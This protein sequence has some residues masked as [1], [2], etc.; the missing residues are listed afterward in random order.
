[1]AGG[2]SFF[3]RLRPVIEAELKVALDA[4]GMARL[5]RHPALRELRVAPRRTRNLLSVYYDTPGHALAAAGLSLRLRRTGGDWVQTIKR[6][7]TV[8]GGFFAHEEVECPAPGGRLVLDGEDATGAIAAVVEAA[9]DAPLAPIFETR[10]QRIT[11]R[12]RAAPGAEVEVALDQGE[13]R[14]GER[15]T[16]ILE[17]EIEL[18]AGDVGAVFEV[19][20]RLFP[21]GPVLFSSENKAARG[22]R[23]AR[24]GVGETPL[25][26]RR[27]G[28]LAVDPAAT[29]E[30]V[31]RDVFRDCLAQIVANMAVVA[32][33]DAPEGP[34][35]LRVGLRRLRTAFLLFGP[36]LG[37]AAM[38]DL[39]A[40][41]RE[42][43]AI[44]G[45]LR[46]AD[47]LIGEVVAHAAGPGLDAA[48]S[49]ALDAALA[50]RRAAI[51]DEV[52]AKLAGRE[53]VGFLFDLGAFIEGRG[54]LAPADYTQSERL[55]APIGEVAPDLLERR[56]RKARKRGRGIRQLDPEA[57]H[58]LRKELK[59]LRYAVDML[60][61]IY[62]GCRRAAAFLKSLKE[63][64]DAF[65]SLNDAAMAEREL[66]GERAPAPGDPDAQRAVGWTLG[67]L[68]VRVAD[69]RP[70]LFERWDELRA[71][72]PFWR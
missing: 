48:A 16:P 45:A 62:A 17:A 25:E 46:D 68:A 57:M 28:S 32:R 56:L 14:A 67:T 41:A 51:R 61:P 65:G 55:A 20:R 22:Y 15:R 69:D 30:A 72:R 70:A 42:L 24:D 2:A 47:V 29:V 52:R 11:E 1:L 21:S 71:A 50:A 43:G 34:H 3:F 39:S 53:A 49:A 35:Q 7:G 4:A 54:W 64:Q 38:V 27:A 58:E 37:E 31:A 33:S 44:V 59:K 26:P 6:Q 12:L 5:R 66:T 36:S 8:S 13:I 9:A 10:V 63:L 40:R 18:A 23:L 19:A 60:G